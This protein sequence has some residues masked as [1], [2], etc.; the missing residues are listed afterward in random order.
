LR[1]SGY[2]QAVLRNGKRGNKMSKYHKY[3]KKPKRFLALTGF[4]VEEFDA[5]LPPF[6]KQFAERMVLYTLSGKKRRNRPYVT[7]NNSPLPSSGEKLFFILTYYQSYPLQEVQAALFGLT[8]PKANQWLHCLTPVYCL[9]F[10]WHNQA[11]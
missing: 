8:Q 7:Y 4:T 2:P 6:E 10:M 1:I 11:A 5:L 9:F 3:R